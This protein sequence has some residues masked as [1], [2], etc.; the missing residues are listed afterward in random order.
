MHKNERCPLSQGQRRK[1]YKWA[2]IGKK[3]SLSRQLQYGHG[4]N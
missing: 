2:L 4:N 3:V 1:L